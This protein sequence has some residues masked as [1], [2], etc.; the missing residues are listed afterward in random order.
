M[1]ARR[2]TISLIMRYVHDTSRMTAPFRNL[3]GDVRRQRRDIVAFMRR[4]V[5]R[6]VHEVPSRAPLRLVVGEEVEVGERDTEW[7]EFV[8]VATTHGSGWVPARYLS[9]TD[10]TAVVRVEY[11]TTELPTQEGDALEVVHEDT[12]SGWL[13]CRAQSGQ[14]GWVPARTVSALD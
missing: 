3:R 6:L 2:G 9:G 11:D 7:P 12:L 13:W 4:A 8:F 5:A 10:S 14:E 1:V